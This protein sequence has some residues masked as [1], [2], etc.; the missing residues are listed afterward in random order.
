[1]T[2]TLRVVLDQL[3]SPTDAELATAS[4]E[5]ARALVRTAPT[6]CEVD[7]IVP[8]GGVDV[9]EAVPG[10]ADVQ[11]AGLRRRELF[12]AWQLG[13]APG[14]G[15]G[16][17]HAPSLMAPL[18]R[19]DRVHE[20]DQTVVT[21]WDLDAWDRADSLSRSAAGWHRLMLKRAQKHADAI[22]VPSHA[23]AARVAELGR[24]G[25]RIRVI[26]GAAPAGFAV[27]GDA[28]G[29]RRTLGLPEGTVVVDGGADLADGAAAV[30]AA[31]LDLPIVIVDVAEGDEP[32]AAEIATV[33][34]IRE[35]QVHVRGRL[36][37]LDRAAVLDGALALVA[38]SRA[39]RFPWRAVE[40]LVLGVPV[41]AAA[42]DDHLEILGDGAVTAPDADSLGA[43]LAEALASSAALDRRAVLAADR[44]RA[45]SWDEHADRV[46]A[47]HAD[48]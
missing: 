10:L 21:L 34:G 27:P 11:S 44:G 24:F 4:R 6:G 37:D 28:V 7:A 26:A 43:A 29:R 47:L 8:G 16:M 41:V 36:D 32:R 23:M 5:L 38:P 22:V 46:W 40:A 20:N 48:L 12:S 35:S 33:A 25:S 15:G 18:V 45:F 1:M 31:R 19:H 17:I 14:I 30:A 2:A 3:V 42:S 39:R 13:I 9:R